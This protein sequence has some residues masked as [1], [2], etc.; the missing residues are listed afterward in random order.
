[1]YCRKQDRGLEIMLNKFTAANAVYD[2]QLKK[3]FQQ[4]LVAGLKESRSVEGII[5]QWSTWTGTNDCSRNTFRAHLDHNVAN[6]KK[7]S[8]VGGEEC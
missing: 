8:Q 3:I 1:M 6:R 4:I 7:K 2:E 5:E